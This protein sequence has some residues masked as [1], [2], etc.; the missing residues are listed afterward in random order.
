MRRTWL[1]GVDSAD[2]ALVLSFAAYGQSLSDDGAV[3]ETMV[4]DLHR[5]PGRR[6]LRA[7]VGAVHD[8]QPPSAAPLVT[9]SLAGACDE[10]G[11]ALGEVP[12]TPLDSTK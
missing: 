3:G 8:L 4:A 10:V 12:H 7:I 9:T 1:R 11:A 5:Y 6:E 2:W